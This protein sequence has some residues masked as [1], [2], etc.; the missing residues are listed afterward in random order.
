MLYRGIRQAE[1]P[2]TFAHRQVLGKDGRRSDAT[3]LRPIAESAQAAA[4]LTLR[5][6]CV[7][8]GRPCEFRTPKQPR[9][10]KPRPYGTQVG[11]ASDRNRSRPT[12][13]ADR[14]TSCVRSCNVHAGLA[15]IVALADEKEKITYTKS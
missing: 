6:I 4:L 11:F 13:H 2:S 9:N 5:A 10:T 15:D 14:R 3:N 7:V 1:R 12:D 8:S